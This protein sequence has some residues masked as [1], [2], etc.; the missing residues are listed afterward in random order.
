MTEAQFLAAAEV[1]LGG[2][3]HSVEPGEEDTGDMAQGLMDHL[4]RHGLELEK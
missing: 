2:Y 1:S 4:K 3:L